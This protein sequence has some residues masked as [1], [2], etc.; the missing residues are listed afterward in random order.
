MQPHEYS[1]I[2]H[3]RASVG[4]GLWLV[5]TLVAS[6]AV[7]VLAMVKDWAAAFG[8]P[9][10]I[11]NAIAFP[12][13]AATIYPLGFVVFNKWIWKWPW[14]SKILGVPNLSG[15][16]ECEGQK[17]GG[18]GISAPEDWQGE[19]VISQT[20]DKIRVYL[21]TGKSDSKSVA[22]S[23]LYEPERGYVLMYSYR[24]EPHLSNEKMSPHVGYCELVLDE[25]LTHGE[26]DYFNN[27]GRV[28]W[29]RMSLRKMNASAQ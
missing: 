17:V 12:V 18:V 8:F 21:R 26:G 13:S 24:N 7:V 28:T 2:G 23:L 4:K 20:W 1:I 25:S 16:W 29:G 3:N 14:I 6:A 22:A 5:M 15:K 19:L 10:V 27:R 9:P 11:I